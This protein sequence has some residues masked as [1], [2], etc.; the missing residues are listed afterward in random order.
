MPLPGEDEALLV[1]EK[2]DHLF[3]ATAVR[4][5]TSVEVEH[6]TEATTRRSP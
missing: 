3:V 6:G 2:V 1:V 4:T 5:T